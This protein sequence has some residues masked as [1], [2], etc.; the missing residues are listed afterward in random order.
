MIFWL[1]WS[2]IV[3]VFIKSHTNNNVMNYQEFSMELAI[4][5]KNN[6]LNQVKNL[7]TVLT[8]FI[9]ASKKPTP[10]YIKQRK[11]WQNDFVDN[12]EKE[13][14]SFSKVSKT[15]KRHLLR[16]GQFDKDT[17]TFK[18]LVSLEK[19]FNFTDK[20]QGRINPKNLVA[21]VNSAALVRGALTEKQFV[22]YLVDGNKITV[23]TYLSAIKKVATATD[24]T[25]KKYRQ[26]SKERSKLLKYT[27]SN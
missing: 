12:V 26:T 6:D 25:F 16:L 7:R 10:E 11:E 24:K 8:A 3:D 4:A 14:L 23:K 19:A 5:I 20:Q 17:R 18:N 22:T 9:N 15:T 2:Y 27:S 13:L 21:A 1:F